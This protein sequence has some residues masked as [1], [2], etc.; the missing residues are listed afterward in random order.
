MYRSLSV[1]LYIKF[2]LLRFDHNLLC[3]SALSQ[4]CSI[5]CNRTF[6]LRLVEIGAQKIKR[7]LKLLLL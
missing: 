1:Y 2:Y 3:F 4:F 6:F 7:D 5:T